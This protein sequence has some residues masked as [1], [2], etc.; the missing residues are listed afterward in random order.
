[1][2]ANNTITNFR[3]ALLTTVGTLWLTSQHKKVSKNFSN[4]YRIKMNVQALSV[5]SLQI[6]NMMQEKFVKNTHL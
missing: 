4:I 1:M 6:P 3:K 5:V 2:L